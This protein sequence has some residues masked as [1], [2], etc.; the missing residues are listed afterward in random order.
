MDAARRYQSALDVACL[1]RSIAAFE[2]TLISANSRFDQYLFGD[3][4][5][6]LTT[7]ERGGWELFAGRA[8]CIDCHD[9]FHRDVN[10]LGGA[11]A[12]F[13]DERF[14]NLGIGYHD[15]AMNDPGRYET[16]RDPEDFGAFKTPMLRNVSRTAPYMHDGSLASLEDVIEFYNR[17]GNKNPNQSAGLK[18]LF[19]S[20]SDKASLVAFLRALDTPAP[21]RGSSAPAIL[22]SP[23][24][25]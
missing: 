14:H 15:G 12:T 23:S 8:A 25:R 17:G 3:R 11:Y 21:H 1:T 9:V 24:A 18:P 19:L 16:T 6:V 5:E 4:R 13:S 7:E 2:R 22:S 20:A 10:P